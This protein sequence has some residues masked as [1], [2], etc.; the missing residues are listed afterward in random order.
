MDVAQYLHVNQKS[1]Y[2][3]MTIV[4]L[5]TSVACYVNLFTQLEA[6]INKSHFKFFSLSWGF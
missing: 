5:D 3:D 4:L 6:K 1:D 2:D